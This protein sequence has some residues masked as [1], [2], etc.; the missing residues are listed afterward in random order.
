MWEWVVLNVLCGEC[1]M[2]A[3]AM[4][5]L[6]TAARIRI[7]QRGRCVWIVWVLILMIFGVGHVSVR[8][9]ERRVL[10]AIKRSV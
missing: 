5:Q 7:Q 8:G 4:G 3:L 2:E 10:V 9:L 6:R 1:V